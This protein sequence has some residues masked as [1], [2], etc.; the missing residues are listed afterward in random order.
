M[1][2]GGGG[3]CGV[4]RIS[5]SIRKLGKFVSVSKHAWHDAV[6]RKHMYVKLYAVPATRQ[7]FMLGRT[8]T[9]PQ[10]ASAIN[11]NRLEQGQGFYNL[12][13]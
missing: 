13:T 8:L 4:N 6:K 9:T 2:V 5:I 3:Q 10:K 11:F 1:V 7:K 12:P